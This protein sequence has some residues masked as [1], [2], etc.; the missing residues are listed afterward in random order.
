MFSTLSPIQVI[1][2]LYPLLCCLL[3]VLI[4]F[5]FTPQAGIENDEAL[6]GGGIYR[7]HGVTYDDQILGHR[8]PLMLMS[9]L[10][11]LKSWVYAPI[12]RF[13]Q[14][15]VSSLR[16]PVILFGGLTI[17]LFSILLRRIAGH[18]AAAVG[19]VLLSTDT[20][21]LLTTCYDWGPVVLQ[22]LLLVGGILCLVRFHQE[23]QPRFLA[24]GFFLLG[25]GLWDKALFIWIL[26]GITAATFVVFP[27]ELWKSLTLR[28]LTTATLAF[29]LGSAPLIIYNIQHPLETFRAN[30]S[31]DA[32]DIPNKAHLLRATLDGRALFGFIARDDPSG[33]RRT[34]ESA[35]ERLSVGLSEKTGGHRIN[36]FAWAFFGAA[37]LAPVLWRT[38]AWRP[39]VFSALAMLI[40]WLQMAL[41]KNTGGSAH[42]TIL[43]WPFPTLFIAVAFAELSRRIS[44]LGKPLLVAVVILVA[45]SGLLVTNEYF[46]QS[47]RNG[48]GES[49]TD[50]IFPLS[51]Y[52]KTVKPQLIYINDWGMFD[53]LHLLHRGRLPLRE[54]S[55]PL[56]KPQLNSEEKDLIL[57]RLE[58]PDSIFVGHPDANELFKGVNAKLRE[59][60]KEAGF[61]RVMLAE[62]PDRNGRMMFEVF[63][64]E[65]SR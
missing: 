56:S 15:S 57:K 28:N 51:D 33:H 47:V 35:I 53:T 22:H 19:A 11:T 20:I 29:S 12:F 4:G 58:E 40:A 60:A 32:G 37:I 9:Y 45:G 3:F 62:I 5:A 36:F 8:V 46:A 2:R 49:W 7:H 65:R 38:P 14:P 25:L 34:P 43:I 21:Y 42:H 18:R 26:S 48:A 24:A 50:A 63:R 10:G 55:D 64:F 17:W 39:L 61:R 23:R 54:G 27:R 1:R 30:A 59:M 41:N 52:L 16:I 6:F 31:Y 13:W 44:F